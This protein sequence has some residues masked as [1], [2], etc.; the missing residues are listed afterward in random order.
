METAQTNSLGSTNARVTT[1]KMG[2]A[3]VSKFSTEYNQAVG[4]TQPG[5][6]RPATIQ[7]RHCFDTS[8]NGGDW[9][10]GRV[11][12]E[13]QIDERGVHVQRN[14]SQAMS[15]IPTFKE[16]YTQVHKIVCDTLDQELPLGFNMKMNMKQR[17]EAIR[18]I[19]KHEPDFHIVGL[20]TALVR[21][22]C[23]RTYN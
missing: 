21:R 8:G 3:V 15:H 7:F 10:A 19:K 16:S 9:I 6:T 22:Q 18:R 13:R 2:A 5:G 4:F 20:G 14:K 23:A 11:E 12:I 17:D 1:A